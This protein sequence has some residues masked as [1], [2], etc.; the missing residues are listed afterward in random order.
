MKG[1]YSSPG[2]KVAM[3]NTLAYYD[4]STI[5]A[6]KNFIGLDPGEKMINV[7]DASRFI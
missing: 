3:A 2:R 6:L 5:T 4:T 1:L 7:V